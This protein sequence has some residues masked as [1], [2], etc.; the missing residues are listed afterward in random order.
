MASCYILILVGSISI[1]LSC[2]LCYLVSSNIVFL[3]LHAQAVFCKQ[4]VLLNALCLCLEGFCVIFPTP[5]HWVYCYSD[6]FI[7]SCIHIMIFW[8]SQFTMR[9]LKFICVVWVLKLFVHVTPIK[10]TQQP[11][12]TIW[13]IGENELCLTNLR[14]GGYLIKYR[15]F[16]NHIVVYWLCI[17]LSSSF[18]TLFHS[19]CQM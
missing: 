4:F 1:C 12:L 7:L 15:P 13:K 11:G 16:F 2:H 8:L 14:G 17:G 5:Q 18:F 9:H 6:M 3:K 19:A 10:F